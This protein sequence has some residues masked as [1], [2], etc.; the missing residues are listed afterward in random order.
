MSLKIITSLH[1]NSL[2]FPAF[3]FTSLHITSR[4]FTSFHYT[5]FPVFHFPALLEVSSSHFQNL[6]RLLT[7][8]YFPKPLPKTV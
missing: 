1:F 5:S 2:H 3:H 8:T 7:Y 6:S 4:H